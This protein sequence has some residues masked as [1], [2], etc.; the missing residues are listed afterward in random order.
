MWRKSSI[1]TFVFLKPKIFFVAVAVALFIYKRIVLGLHELLSVL[2]TFVGEDI[3]LKLNFVCFVSS[4]RRTYFAFREDPFQNGLDRQESK[5]KV[6][7]LVPILIVQ[8]LPTVF[9][10]IKSCQSERKVRWHT[11]EPTFYVQHISFLSL[12]APPSL[13]PSPPARPAACFVFC[14]RR[15]YQSDFLLHGPT[16][17]SFL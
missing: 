17:P 7:K 3:L 4:L 6:T 16:M 15:Y 9:I 13:C 2:D 1:Q 11:P 8:N 14:I 5:W 10:S 12:P